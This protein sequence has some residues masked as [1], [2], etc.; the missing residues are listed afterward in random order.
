MWWK[1][2]S[3][4]ASLALRI[5]SAII[6]PPTFTFVL[7]SHESTS[8]DFRIFR[9]TLPASRGDP[10]CWT[11]LIWSAIH[12]SILSA[13]SPLL[14]LRMFTSLSIQCPISFANLMI[15]VGLL[16]LVRM[17]FTTVSSVMTASV[18]DGNMSMYGPYCSRS[19][20]RTFFLI[21]TS[22]ELISARKGS[23]HPRN[24]R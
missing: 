11:A 19:L 7:S 10:F 20:P 22:S 13:L 21:R 17:E 23:Y 3:P 8:N 15:G 16:P 14:A 6:A 2:G 9:S 12:H 18:C 24:M 1:A 4:S 5:M